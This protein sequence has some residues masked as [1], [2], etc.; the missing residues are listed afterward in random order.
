LQGQGGKDR[1]SFGTNM[2]T[3]E[4]TVDSSLAQERDT[5]KVRVVARFHERKFGQKNTNNGDKRALLKVQ[6]GADQ[7]SRRPQ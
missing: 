6:G 5:P 4:D 1:V 2:F 3:E 7:R